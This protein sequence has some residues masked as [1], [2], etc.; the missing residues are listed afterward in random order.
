MENII[1]NDEILETAE[2]IITESANKGLPALII[3]GSCVILGTVIYVGKKTVF[4]KHIAPALAMRKAK[5]DAEA[6][7]R[8]KVFYK[9]SDG[10]I[11]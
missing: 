10:E 7:L 1:T 8:N 9:T 2:E 11:V 5:K 4:E 6:M 3:A